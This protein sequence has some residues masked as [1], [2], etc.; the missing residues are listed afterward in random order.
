[1][2]YAADGQSVSIA[3]QDEGPGFGTIDIDELLQPGF[4]T[5]VEGSGFGLFLA[6]RII[7]EHGGRLSLESAPSGG[8]IVRFELPGVTAA[9]EPVGGGV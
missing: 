3:V 4:T 6:R 5:K 9:G 8:A 1:M 2:A 7:E